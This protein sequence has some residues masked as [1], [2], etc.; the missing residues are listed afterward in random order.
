[1]PLA[2]IRDG[3]RV[4]PEIA[5][6]FDVRLGIGNSLVDAVRIALADRRSLLVLDNIEQIIEAGSDIARLLDVCPRL[7]I[8]ATG[9]SPFRIYGEHRVPV[10][11]LPVPTT[12]SEEALDTARSNEAVGLFT[13]RA[14]AARPDFQLDETNAA[15][16]LDI[17]RRL[18]GL[19][20]A[21]ELP[22]ARIRILSPNALLAQ[23]SQRLKLLTGGSVNQPERL[24]TMRAAIAWS[25]DLLSPDKQRLFRSLAVFSGG[26]T[27]EA[28]V[29]VAVTRDGVP[30]G[31]VEMLDALTSLADRRLIHVDQRS[32]S[33]VRFTMLETIG[34]YAWE[35]VEHAAE[36]RTLA[37]ATRSTSPPWRS[38][39]MRCCGAESIVQ[40]LPC[41][42]KTGRTFAPRC[43]G[44]RK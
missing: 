36:G 9:R 18:D 35:C 29:A 3:L 24:Q 19:P 27:L 33:T 21:I 41:S 40:F 17:C 4:L 42:M 26:F 22:A 23:L 32:A 20:V 14:R 44:W 5:A 15:I 39:E 12:S 2:A 37:F 31:E 13:Q 6:A 8:L 34:E 7:R 43:P 25:Y 10:L 38:M 30:A 11:P 1:M 16:L 28:A